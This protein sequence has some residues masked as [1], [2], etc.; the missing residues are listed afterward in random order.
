MIHSDETILRKLNPEADLPGLVQLRVELEA[1]DRLGADTSEAALRVQFD[2]PDHD[3]SQDRMVIENSKDGRLIG[4]GWTVSQ[5][6][7]RAFLGVDIHPEWR[8]RGLG[9]QLLEAMIGRAKEKGAL[10]IVSGAGANNRVGHPF[11]T[12]RGFKLAGHS[13]FM[14]ASKEVLP[15]NPVWHRGFGL[16][17]FQEMGDI[18]LLVEGSNRCYTDMWGHRENLVPASADRFLDRMQSH[19]NYYFP[20]GI[21][22]IIDPEGQLAGICFNRLEGDEKKKVIDSPGVV[23]EYRL[24]GLQRPLV[25]ASMRWL[26]QQAEGETHLYTWGDFEAA[27]QIYLELGFTLSEDNH[28]IDYVLK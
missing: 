4:H 18:S 6:P 10:Q 24:L 2:W 17:S 27:V 13:R 5:S 28:F 23:P 9:S 3:P 1:H 12:A 7:Q 22:I 25:Q 14:T 26:N 16:R 21:F 19:P 8:R 11:L 15:E 20:K